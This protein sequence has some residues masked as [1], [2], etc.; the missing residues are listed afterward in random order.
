MNK[1]KIFATSLA[2]VLLVSINFFQAIKND[3]VNYDDEILVVRNDNIKVFSFQSIKNFFIYPYQGLYHPIV[4]L[5]YAVEYKLFGLNP[6]IFHLNNVILHLFNCFFVFY[7]FYLL[8][9]NFVISFFVSILFGIHPLQVE[10]VVWISARKDVLYA[11]F[12]LI[13]IISYIHYIRKNEKKFYHISIVMFLLSLMS[14]VM[15]VSLPLVLLLIDYVF[16][17]EEI[18]KKYYK[19]F[20]NKDFL[21]KCVTKKIPFFIGSI[22]F[23]IIGFFIHFPIEQVVVDNRISFLSGIYNASYGIILYIKN[24]FYPTKLSVLYPTFEKVV[25]QNWFW[26]FSV[27]IFVV[28]G[29]FLV[30]VENK[31]VLFGIIFFVIT[32]FPVLNFIPI[33]LGVPSDRYVYISSLGIFY[34]GALLW[35]FFI[36]KYNR[37]DKYFYILFVF[38]IILLSNTTFNRILVW[39]DSIFLWSDVIK[40]YPLE[41][42]AYSNRAMIYFRKKMYNEAIKDYTKAIKLKPNSANYYYDRGLLYFN[43]QE[44]E[45]SLKDYTR[46]IELNDKY[47]EAYNNR[48]NVYFV[49]K[50]FDEAINDYNKV[51]SINPDFINCRNNRGLAYFYKKEYKKS[52]DDFMYILNKGYKVN[53]KL[54]LEIR[55]KI[56]EKKL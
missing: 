25:I 46:A 32:I 41:N 55:E 19:N 26:W 2:V 5:S 47:L 23:S 13:S 43:I 4:L 18:I 30:L 8:E 49:K 45:K 36:Q 27:V 42:R 51:L 53:D 28:I 1:K 22:F 3:F 37:Y 50:K 24:I 11:F 33:G 20:S 40:K 31:K 39:R 7:I 15:A 54:L 44:Y 10:P 6:A 38:I 12:Y 16:L 14:K 52:Y 34:L 9:K 17:K 29:I 56:N 21:I 48:G 35:N